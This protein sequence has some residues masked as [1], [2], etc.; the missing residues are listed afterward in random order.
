MKFGRA[1]VLVVASMEGLTQQEWHPLV[2]EV[3]LVE[4]SV[5][6]CIKERQRLVEP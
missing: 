4:V 1:A 6:A 3:P 2:L 5:A